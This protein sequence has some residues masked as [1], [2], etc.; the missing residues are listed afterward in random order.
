MGNPSSKEALKR[1][2]AFHGFHI[3]I[4]EWNRGE[5]WEGGVGATEKLREGKWGHI[6]EE[7]EVAERK[8]QVGGVI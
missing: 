8:G 3:K 6:D 7:Y 2:S 4:V 5:M 1:H